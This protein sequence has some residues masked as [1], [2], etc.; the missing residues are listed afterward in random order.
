MPESDKKIEM[1]GQAVFEG[2][3]MR[4]PTGYAIAVR[5]QDKTIRIKTVPYK[6]LTKRV[7]I[8]GIPFL[9]GVVMLFEMLAI[10]L[11]GLDFSVNEWEGVEK[12]KGGVKPEGAHASGEQQSDAEKGARPGEKRQ[13]SPMAMA[14]LMVF[15][16]GVALFMTVV[17]PNFLTYL[18]GV[19]LGLI[20]AFREAAVS[21]SGGR[22]VLVEENSPLLY[23][24]IAGFFRACILITYIW[25]VSLNKEIR[26]V[27]EF[28]GAE[29]KAVFAFE[30]KKPLTVAN[31]RPYTTRHPRCGTTFLGV[32]IIVS[33]IVFSILSKLILT[34]YPEFS[35][36]TFIARKLIL[37]LMH[38]IFMPIVAG[39]AYEVIKFGARHPNNP[40]TMLLAWPGMMSQHITTREPD[41]EQLEVSI[42]SLK[43]A[44]SITPEHREPSLVDIRPGDPLPFQD[45]SA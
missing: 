17:L 45:E 43:A 26:R 12:D 1:G 3:M 36:M 24:L 22:S 15:S 28:H 29:H 21:G 40:V 27:F 13:I 9:R 39:T 35:Q 42:L 25:I 30:D 41:D 32:V 7:K 44:L 18:V 31:V 38:I 5:K 23:N 14:G 8:L 34:L 19:L 33:I 20:P 2:V 6:A 4:S 37:I 11:K 16:L 10:G